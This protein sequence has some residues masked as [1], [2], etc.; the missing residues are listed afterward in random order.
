M[1]TIG[2]YI[3]ECY[4][5]ECADAAWAIVRKK[6]EALK[7]NGL[8]DETDNQKKSCDY[9]WIATDG[10]FYPVEFGEHQAWAANY[11]LKEYRKGNVQLEHNEDPGDKLCD[12]GFILIHNPSLHNFSVTRNKSKRITIKQKEALLD[13][14]EQHNMPDWINKL[15]QEEL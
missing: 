4:I 9:G 8:C 5:N 15:L 13:Y 6:K 7:K 2:K 3:N 12:M 14:F 1:I 11:L 10:T